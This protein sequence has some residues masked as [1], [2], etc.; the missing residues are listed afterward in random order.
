MPKEGALSPI[1]RQ[2][3]FFPLWGW[4][5][6]NVQ[7][8]FVSS[9]PQMSQAPSW[10][11]RCSWAGLQRWGRS[12]LQWLLHVSTISDVSS[13]NKP[14]LWFHGELRLLLKTEPPR[15]YFA[16]CYDNFSTPTL[17]MLKSTENNDRN[18]KPLT[19]EET[20]SVTVSQRDSVTACVTLIVKSICCDNCGWWTGLDSTR[21]NIKLNYMILLRQHLSS[22]NLK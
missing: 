10:Y 15:L 7:P 3:I 2:E 16:H 1:L 17:Q 18:D 4:R 22:V 12:N 8:L 14:V 21:N 13:T 5:S 9:Q 20:D 19:R 6:N 11:W